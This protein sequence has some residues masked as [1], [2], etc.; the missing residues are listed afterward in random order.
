MIEEEQG[1]F[2]RDPL[3]QPTEINRTI[4]RVQQ[5]IHRQAA[6]T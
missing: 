1:A 2:D 6:A 5:L 3:R 4:R